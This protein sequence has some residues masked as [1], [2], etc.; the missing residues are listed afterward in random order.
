MTLEKQQDVEFFYSFAARLRHRV[1]KGGNPN[2]QFISFTL[3]LDTLE[4]KFP[5]WLR[6]NG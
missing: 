1:L 4:L 6:I 2:Q 5:N 3:D